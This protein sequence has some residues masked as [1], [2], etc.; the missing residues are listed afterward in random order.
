MKSIS[1]FF[2]VCSFRFQNFGSVKD[3]K[4]KKV[5][6]ERK[7]IRKYLTRIKLFLD[8]I[9]DIPSQTFNRVRVS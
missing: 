5:G 1:S 9:L 8:R 4:K 7:T 2:F 6:K 3:R